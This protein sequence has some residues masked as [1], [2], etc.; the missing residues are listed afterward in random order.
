[1]FTDK[2]DSAPWMTHDKA[3]P[4]PDDNKKVW[5][6]QAELRAKYP[7][8]PGS[9]QVYLDDAT[10]PGLTR[11][12]YKCGEKNI[13][14][15]KHT[16][17]TDKVLFYVHGGGF[18][19]GNG[20]YCR[21]NGMRQADKIGLDVI[22]NEYST[23]PEAKEPIALN[24][25]EAAWEFLQKELGYKPSQ[26]IITGDSAGGTLGLGLLH[27]LKA[28]GKELP[29]ACVWFSPCLDLQCNGA[30]HTDNIGKDRFFPNGIKAFMPAYIEDLTHLTVPEIS[31]I[32]GDYKGFPPMYFCSEDTEVMCSDVLTAAE[33]L[34]AAGGKP[35]VHCYHGYW[36]TFPVT[37]PVA[38]LGWDALDEIK[39]WVKNI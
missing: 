19:R 6:E 33:K 31:P 37:W 3:D 35:K 29:R 16:P 12:D 20:K 10:L 22:I 27:R 30:S 26:V 28:K 34:H 1:M 5:D 24:E 14:V 4:Y 17:A 9:E 13:F 11:T 7:M 36:H 18:I 21:V 8:K 32:N 15:Y 38:Q 23:A 39:D 25:T 2:Y